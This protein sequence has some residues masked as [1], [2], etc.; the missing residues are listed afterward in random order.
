M[1]FIFLSICIVLCTDSFAQVDTAFILKIKSLDTLNSLRFDTTSV[2]DD[3]LTQK[4]KIL[5]KEKNGIDLE[6]LIFIKLA[7]QKQKDTIHDAAFYQKL[8]KEIKSGN[9]GRLIEN[10][11]LNLY[12]KTFSLSEI[13]DLIAFYKTSAGKKMNKEFIMMVLQA[14]KDAEIL[15]H[16]A[17]ENN[18]H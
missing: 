13:N 1:K 17:I 15:V 14:A 12:R 16:H 10:C 7:E 6:T 9:T 3:L 18:Q 5:R 8:N 11:V 2:P 4:I